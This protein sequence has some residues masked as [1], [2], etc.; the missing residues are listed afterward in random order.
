MKKSRRGLAALASLLI[1][2]VIGAVPAGADA[3]DAANVS[4]INA[5]EA[6]LDAAFERNDP[7]EIRRAMT[8]DHLSVTPYYDG[9][10]T[11]GAQIASLKDLKFS[12]KLVDKPKVILLGREVAMRTFTAEFIGTYKGQEM[13][14]RQFVT[15]VLVKRGGRWMERF[16]RQP[17]SANDRGGRAG[18]RGVSH[19]QSTVSTSVPM[20]LPRVLR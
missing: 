6:A 3:E 8:S 1:Y 12:Q 18:G 4:A 13:P 14:R 20:N 10:Q 2:V 16:I 19:P 9:P 7:K 5:V 11:T 15:A 17:P